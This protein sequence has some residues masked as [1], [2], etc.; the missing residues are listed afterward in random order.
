M[1]R[2]VLFAVISFI[3]SGCTAPPHIF[4]VTTD[5]A[6]SEAILEINGQSVKLAKRNG[7]FGG[8]SS[9]SDGAGKITVKLES[10]ASVICPIGYITNGELE[11]HRFAIKQGQCVGS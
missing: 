4:V 11:P 3:I 8:D 6:A 2:C 7:R 10:G 1:V 9:V 5:E